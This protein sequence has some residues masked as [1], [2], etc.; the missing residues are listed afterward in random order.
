MPLT[1]LVPANWVVPISVVS[2]APPATTR[3]APAVPMV[4]RSIVTFAPDSVV[5]PL[6][7]SVTS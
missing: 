1:V 4:S 6:A 3:L 7:L 2:D 5:V